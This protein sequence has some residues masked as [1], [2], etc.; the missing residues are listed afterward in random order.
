MVGVEMSNVLQHAH[1]AHPARIYTK[2]VHNPTKCTREIPSILV[3][4][5]S[6]DFQTPLCCPSGLRCC[7]TINTTHCHPLHITI[8]T[9]HC[10]T[11]FLQL[12]RYLCLPCRQN[13]DARIQCTSLTL[14]IAVVGHHRQVL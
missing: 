12:I 4:Y 1:L 14:K 6:L 7:V 5:V 8:P 9:T 3:I 2:Y 11:R 13:R 10:N